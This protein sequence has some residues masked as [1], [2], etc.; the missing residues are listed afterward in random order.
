MLSLEEL[1]PV[2]IA[3]ELIIREPARWVHCRF[4]L[5]GI[6]RIKVYTERL[7][8]KGLTFSGNKG[9]ERVGISTTS[10]PGFSPTHPYRVRERP[11]LGLVIWLQNKINSEGGVLCLSF[12]LFHSREISAWTGILPLDKEVY[13]IFCLAIGP[14]QYTAKPTTF[15]RSYSASGT[16]LI[17]WTVNILDL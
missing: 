2:S 15:K 13:F 1:K 9:Y 4:I 5:R 10:F 11:W 8:P 14:N 6:L 17:C 7:Q 16:G 3:L 12:F